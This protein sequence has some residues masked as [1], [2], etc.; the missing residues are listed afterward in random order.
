MHQNSVYAWHATPLV[1]A[2]TNE[3]LQLQVD[4]FG[5]ARHDQK[6]KKA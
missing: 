1:N 6:G 2:W 5:V 3:D 4:R